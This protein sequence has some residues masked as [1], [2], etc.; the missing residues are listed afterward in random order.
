MGA[1]HFSGPLFVGGVPIPT[2]ANPYLPPPRKSWFVNTDA[3][4]NGDGTSMDK[5]FDTMAEALSAASTRDHI[6][7]TGDV[8]EELTG[9]NL[10]FD[11]CFI[12]VAGNHH[13]DLPAA[14]YKTGA[15]CWRPP[16]SPTAATP[17]LIVRG[18][19]WKF[20]GGLFDIP[21]DAAAIKLERNALS[22][23]SEYDASHAAFYGV[24]FSAGKYAIEDNGGC[25]NI[26][27]YGCE[28]NQCTTTAIV[29]TSTSVANPLNWKIIGNLFP[30]NVSSFGN[31]THIDTPL[32]CAH[33]KYNDFG[34]VV[35]TAAYIDLTG[36]NGN[37]VS[38]NT[39]SGEYDTSNYISGTGDIWPQ[40]A[41]AVTTTTAPD[42]VSIAVPAA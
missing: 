17:L 19:G 23:T 42:G 33:I 14:G 41:C 7:W 25:Y 16:A 18:R 26:G 31:A 32:N 9:S 6:Y 3:D 20:F 22:T 2:V 13:P 40:N 5:P 27:I 28:F 21:V 30:S 1:S 4:R 39:L 8:R 36:G 35:S 37:I 12:A 29:N 15:S 34:T 10:V 11:L 24:R 38:F